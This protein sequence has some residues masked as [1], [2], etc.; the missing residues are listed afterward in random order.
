MA[1]PAIDYA[2][3]AKQAGA[4]KSVPPPAA[5]VAAAP[6]DPASATPPAVDYAAMAKDAGAV[7]STPASDA[8]PS[9]NFAVVNGHRVSLDGLPP[10]VQ[11]Q[12]NDHSDQGDILLSN[13][14][15]QGMIGA[16]KGAGDTVNNLGRLALHTPIVGRFLKAANT[17]MYG[18]TPE[19]QDAAFTEL[20]KNLTATTTAQKVG[21]VAEQVGETILPASKVAGAGEALA[22]AAAPALVPAIGET[23]ARALP[24]AI[25]EGAGMAGVSAA[26]GGNPVVG[27]VLGAAGPVAGELVNSLE[28]GLRATAEKKVVQALGPTKERYKAIA[29][30]LAPNILKRGLGGSREALQAQAADTLDTV[31]TQLDAVLAKHGADQLSVQ[32]VVD[33]L[34]TAKDAFRAT[35][36]ASG[37]IVPLEPRALRQLDGL[38]KVVAALGPDATVENLTAVRQAWDKV[39]AQAGG[40]DHRAAGAI[41]VPLRDQSEAWAKREGASAIRKVLADGVPDLAAVNKEYSFWKGL[42][43]V[44]TQTLKRTQPQ[45]P[46]LASALAEGA[47]AVVGGAAGSAAGPGGALGGAL[48]T[49]KLAAM[50][51]AAFESPRW[52]LVDAKLRNS[53]A[54]AIQSGSASKVTG[55]LSQIT[56][57]QA[58]KI[59]GTP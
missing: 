1:S 12:L 58:S 14:V 28:P 33:A 46:G 3:L 31:G 37:E 55:L 4:F 40:F 2:A 25:V 45:G 8:A 10:D 54:D 7:S 11:K 29:E 42:S 22:R 13:P 59:G 27:G 34:E 39:V 50:A 38:Q 53:L 41:G 36:P 20:E 17:A 21:K 19:Q 23:A 49:G 16:A 56:A 15:V 44:L 18:L 30:R 5:P 32:P 57:V 52:K 6:A 48:F 24:R 51:K 47:G 35:N 43:D 9:M 26:Q